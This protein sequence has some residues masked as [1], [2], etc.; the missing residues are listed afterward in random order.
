MAGT[1][2]KVKSGDPLVI[3]AATFNTFVDAARDFQERQ[4]A[5][6]REAKREFRQTGI[7][8]VR[9]ESGADRARFDVLGIAGPII[10]PVDHAEEFKQR[11]ALKGVVPSSAHTGKFAILLEPATDQ[12]IVRA[13]LDGVCPARVRMDDEAH[14][15]ADIEVGQA[16]QLTSGDGGAARL[17]WVEPVEDRADPEI[18]WTV[19]RIGGG[20]AGGTASALFAMI[21]S[22][23]G[24]LPP[25]RYAATDA[26]MDEDGVWTQVV[27]GAAYNNL[28]NLDEQGAG[29]QWVNP[30]LVGDVVLIFPAP[31]GADAHVCTRS[32]YRGTY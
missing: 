2:H 24:T 18:A 5:T 13:C 26:T 25:Y 11:V 21:T 28:F 6:A 20:G 12:T 16:G 23:A 3:P 14:E 1:L 4:R 9:N 7:V 17:L 10:K 8:L 27:D 29:G 22:K 32:H 31:G 15:F 30:L 19:V